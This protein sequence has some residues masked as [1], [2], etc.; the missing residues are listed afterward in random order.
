MVK[1]DDWETLS[2]KCVESQHFDYWLIEI[3]ANLIRFKNERNFL[4][5]AHLVDEMGAIRAPASHK[6]V[7]LFNRPLWAKACVQGCFFVFAAKK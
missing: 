2:G 4:Y 1:T 3:D 7:T 6:G 5:N